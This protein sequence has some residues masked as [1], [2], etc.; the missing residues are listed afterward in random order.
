MTLGEKVD[1]AVKRLKAFEPPEGYYL[2]FSGGKDSVVCKAL[3]DRAGVKYDAHYNV[4]SVDPPELVRFILD[5]HKDVHFDIPHYAD[6]TPITMWNLIPKQLIPPTQLVR[7]CCKH[8]KERGGE[9][10]F[11]VTGVRWEESARRKNNRGIVEQQFAGNDNTDISDADLSIWQRNKSGG[12][13]LVNDNDEAR[14]QLEH[15]Q[16]KGKWVLNPIIDWTYRN[17]WDFTYNEQ[18]PYCCKYD[19][20]RCR[21]GCIGCPMG[22]RK[23]MLE[24]FAE[25][26]KYKEAYLRAFGKMIEERK[27]RNLHNKTR[28]ETPE[29][30]FRWWTR[31]PNGEDQITM[32]DDA[33]G[34]TDGEK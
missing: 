7:Y 23:Q 34:D 19:Q 17:V 15:C 10:R 24:D 3:C 1:A 22:G 25:Y 14:R 30:V 28:W 20:G 5:Y 18:L 8:L 26:P 31:D 9:G 16:I 29:Q 13:I 32:F 11:C 6:G 21:L 33:G 4:T 12:L 2:A 27:K